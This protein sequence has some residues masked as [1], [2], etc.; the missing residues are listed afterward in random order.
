VLESEGSRRL[1]PI[2]FARFKKC[3]QVTLL[4]PDS[5]SFAGT[6]QSVMDKNAILAPLVDEGD[7]YPCFLCS[8]F[9]RE[10]H[11]WSG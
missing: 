4:N 9:W 6:T 1:L 2:S 7:G 8:L 10:L 11:G 3:I 5:P